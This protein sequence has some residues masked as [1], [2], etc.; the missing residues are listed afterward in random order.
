MSIILKE[1]KKYANKAKAKLLSGFFK[2]GK[3]EY[4]YGDVF[5]G[6]TVPYSRRVVKEVYGKVDLK[7]LKQSIH[8]KFH[9][10][11]LVALLLLVEMYKRNKNK[12]EIYDFYL[13]NIEGINNWDLVDLSA[14]NIVGEYLLDGNKKILERLALE[15]NLWKKRIAIISTLTFIRKG[16]FEWTFK[17]SKI[18]LEDKHDLIHKAVGWM[19]R[20]AWKRD[21]KPVERFLK[22]N[23]NKL[24]R[25]TLRYAIE[26]VEE[27]RRKEMLKGNF[28]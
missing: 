27:K 13:N 1:L 2:T 16:D 7:N 25:T 5:L 3:G 4:G 11:R 24:P 14:P 17:I 12:R 6:I 19:L 9:E 22:E 26:R 18:L 21:S 10:E 20:E 8:S 28:D 23:Y 15:N